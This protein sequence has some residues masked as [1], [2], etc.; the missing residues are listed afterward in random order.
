MANTKKDR[1]ELNWFLQLITLGDRFSARDFFDR[2]KKG[3]VEFLIV[4]F[5]VLVSF[6]VEQQGEDFDDR[7]KNIDNLENLRNELLEMQEYTKIYIDQNEWVTDLF[8]KQYER[9][10]ADN[11]SVFLYYDENLFEEHFPPLAFYTTRDPFNPP[12]V[13]YDA[14]QLDGTFRFLG[15]EIGKKMK[16]NYDG[17]ELKY[18]MI[19]TD[20]EEKAFIDDYNKRIANQWVFDL[21]RIEVNN[22][23]FWLKNREYIQNDRFMRYNLLK[24]LELWGEIREQL[25]QYNGQLENNIKFLD[26]IINEKNDEWTLIWWWGD[27]PDWLRASPKLTTEELPDQEPLAAQ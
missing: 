15:T 8:Q 13:V 7:G 11:D 1:K 18:L 17:V 10:D 25:S 27:K 16:E 5:G 26:S 21:G 3:F 24:R 4:F 14:I 6:S 2:L 20:K 12:R 19:N 22:N 23:L 9:W